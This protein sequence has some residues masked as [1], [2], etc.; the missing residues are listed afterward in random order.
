LPKFTL[1]YA[2]SKPSSLLLLPEL[3]ALQKEFPDQVDLHLHVDNLDKET[4]Q[5]LSWSD[6]LLSRPPRI[7]EQDIH[8]GRINKDAIRLAVDRSKDKGSRKILV[9]GPDGMVTSV[10]GP[11]QGKKQGQLGGIL[12]SLD[13]REDEVWKL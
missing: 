1:L 11:K 8:E 9:C 2:A 5:G 12:A 4:K 13:V 10:A 7:E 3:A 6:W